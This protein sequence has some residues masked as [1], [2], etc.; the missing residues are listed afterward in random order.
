MLND[1][2][3]YDGKQM[4]FERAFAMQAEIE[5]IK[6]NRRNSMNLACVGG[7]WVNAASVVQW[8]LKRPFYYYY[9]Y[10]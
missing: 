1:G 5:L 10:Y 9:H 6:R 4:R 2:D 8:I 3:D 7:K